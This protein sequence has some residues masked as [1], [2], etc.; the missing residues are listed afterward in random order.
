MSVSRLSQ[1]AAPTFSRLKR[2]QALTAKTAVKVTMMRAIAT[3]FMTPNLAHD[4]AEMR[5]LRAQQAPQP[6]AK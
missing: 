5:V 4:G 1:V 3:G 2:R 6:A